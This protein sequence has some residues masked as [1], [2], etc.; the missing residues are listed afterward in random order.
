MALGRVATPANDI[1]SLA[2]YRHRHA[3]YRLDADLQ[4]L[5]AKM[6]WITVWD[7][8][9]FANNAYKDG[10]ENHNPATQGEWS[11]RKAAAAKA[12]HEWLPIRTADTANLLKIYRHFDFGKLLSLHMLDTRIEGRDRQYDNF[13]DPDG[14]ITRYIKGVTP[15]AGVL[16]DASRRMISTEQQDWLT[17]GLTAST[18]AWQFLGNQDIMARMWFPASVLSKQA[19][20]FASPPTATLAEVTAAINDYLTAKATR[21]TAGPGALTP[22]QAA[23]LNPKIN[24][25]LPYNLDAWDG[26]PVQRDAILTTVKSLNKNL[27]VLSGDSHNG[28]FTQLTTLAGVKAGVEFAGSSVTSSGFESVGL[29]EL[30]SS[31]DG[32]ALVPQLGTAAIGAGLGLVNDLNYVD[33]KRRGYLL[34]TVTAASVKGEYVFVNTVKSKTYTAS[35]GKTIT[36]TALGAVTYA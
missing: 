3:Q 20:A 13:G 7:D 1:V 21:A 16:P 15:V 22:V 12:Y 2:D 5:H 19:A 9:E 10:A 28:W 4:A 24:P 34:M 25:T 33:T 26:Y 27:V 17:A 14:G 31:L 30:A 32:S 11:A 23:L 8:H 35:I 29:G 6:P 36:V 18:A